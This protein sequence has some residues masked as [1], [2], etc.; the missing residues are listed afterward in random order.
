MRGGGQELFICY[1]RAYH[2]L[3]FARSEP[4]SRNRRAGAAGGGLA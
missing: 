4:P 3:H 1:G 2:D